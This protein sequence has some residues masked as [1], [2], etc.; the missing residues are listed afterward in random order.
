MENTGTAIDE[1]AM[2]GRTTC[3]FMRSALKAGLL[4]FDGRTA[5][6]ARLRDLLG[7]GL[8][9]LGQVAKFFARRNHTTPDM[10]P[11]RYDPLNLV[12]SRGDHPGDSGMLTAQGFDPARFDAFTGHARTGPDGRRYMTASDFGAA[13]AEDLA[14]DPRARVGPKDVLFAND[15]RNSAG[16]FG[17]LL[18]AFGRP[19]PDGPDRGEK[20]VAVDDMRLLFERSEFPAGWRETVARSS[21]LG[22]TMVSFGLSG[23]GGIYGA[24]RE[25]YARLR[26]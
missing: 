13:I 24:A 25:A 8:N 5:P 22:W 18:E 7:G 20:A 4:E 10:A 2:E 17:L 19:L 23:F 9:G 15:M 6:Q 26:G 14:R 1:K 16:E 11:G 21:A 3:P 12:G